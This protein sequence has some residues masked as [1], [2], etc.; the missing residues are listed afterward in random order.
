MS[1]IECPREQD[2]L[3]AIAA[4]RWPDRDVDLRAHVEACEVC[5]D[6]ADVASALTY[7]HQASVEEM[8]ALPSADVVWWRA[9]IRARTDAAHAA[10]R[11]IAVV[12]ALAIACAV[13]VVVGLAGNAAWGLPLWA[14]WFTGATAAVAAAAGTDAVGLALRGG[15]LAIGVWLVLA[16]VAVYLATDD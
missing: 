13:G 4:C 11:P 12:Q 2:V 6:L 16:P 15:V 9:Q 8:T 10:S 7:E 3:D 5:R 1:P 14:R